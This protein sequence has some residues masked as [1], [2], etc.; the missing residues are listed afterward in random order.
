M[1]LAI[2]IIAAAVISS[3]FRALT[4]WATQYK[5]D[6][7]HHLST[8]LGEPVTISTMETGWYWFEPVIKL[9]QVEVLDGSKAVLKL[10]KLF[11]GINIFSSLWHWQIQPGVLFIDDLH[12]N[13]RQTDEGWQIDGIANRQNMAFDTETLK[14]I[15]E[16]ILDQQKI[17]LKDVSAH[18]F[19]KDGTVI[20]FDDLDLSIANHS[21]HYR[22][23][24]NAFL[25]Q[26]TATKFE[27]LADLYLDADALNKTSGHAF[28]SVHQ[29]LPAQWQKFLPQNRF[30]ILGGK[31]DVQLWA[32][33]NKGN[34]TNAQGRLNF[35]HLAWADTDTEKGQ[36][37]QSL[38]ANLAWAPQNDGS[39][40]LTGDHIGLRLSGTS[41]PE[42]SFV[43]RY[44]QTTKN[45]FIY[46]KNILLQSLCSTSIAWPESMHTI[47][48]MKPYGELHDTQ[49]Y[50]NNEKIDYV[51][52]RFV[53]LGWL[54]S[55]SR[56]GAENLSGVI[57]WQPTEGRL[58]FDSKNAVI[59]PQNQPPINF[60]LLNAAFDWK[61]LDQGLRVSM[62]RLVL[63]HS[64]LLFSAQGVADE[65]SKDSMGPVRLKAQFSA[66]NAEE[67]MPYLPSKHLK[68]K[69]DA[70]LKNDI[71]HIAKMTGELTLNG[72]MKD[73]PFDTQ[74]G[75]FSIKSYLSGV[76]LV[77]ARNWPVTREIEAYLNVTKRTL[78]ADI[79][80]AN[81]Q[82]IEVDKGNLRVND[83]GLD[84]ETLLIHTKAE[85]DAKKA[86]AYVRASP[87]NKKLSALNI[88]QMKGPVAV[89]LQLEAPL[90]PENDDILA[91]GDIVFNKNNVQVHHAIDDVELKNLSGTLQF[92]QDSVL[93]S[94][95]QAL[96]LGNPVTILIKS[97]KGPSPSTE[98]RVKGQTNISV[99]RDKFKLPVFSL[100]Q[101]SLWLESLLTITD[102]PSD[103]DHVRIQTSL[104]GLNIDLPPP[105]GKTKD[106]KV[107]LKIDID[108]NSK[109]AVRLRFNYDNRLSSD[110]LFS[111]VKGAFA[112]QKGKIILGNTDTSND[113]QL[114]GLQ[115]LGSLPEFD[116]QQW[117]AVKEKMT[118]DNQEMPN[119]LS[120]ID[121][122][123]E[124]AKVFNQSYK[125]LSFKAKKQEKGN[126]EIRLNQEKIAANLRYQP[127][128]NTVT[129]LFE[130]LHL[131]NE[132]PVDFKSASKLKPT[133]LP[134]LNLRVA[135]FQVGELNIGDV[136]LK[137]TA[138][139]DQWEL[140]TCKIKSPFYELTARGNWREN[141]KIN[142]TQLQAD[143]HITNLA[144]SLENWKVSPVVEANKGDVQFRGGWSGPIYKFSLAKLHGQLA[145]R[146]KDGR[147]TNLSP[148]TEEKLGLGK[149]LSILSL[150]TIP[151]RLKLDFSDLSEDG[152]SFDEFSGSFT[153]SKGVMATQDSYIDGPVAYA[154]MKG[155]LDI[156]KQYYDL[157]LKVNPHITASLPVVATIAGG[158]IAGIATWVAS[159]LINQGMQKI[160]GYTYKISG[161]WRQPVVQQIKI[162][163]KRN[164]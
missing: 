64:N 3:L 40:Q 18:L 116:L 7:E 155:N 140:N 143:L 157:D 75:E 80:H 29:V 4:P 11:V 84:R 68:R 156:A 81:L 82:G 73:F 133:N 96:L 117:L 15:L 154:S 152:Y 59:V 119:A 70:W 126:W 163:K 144:K 41:W 67:W 158:P 38:K 160:S 78:E 23:K 95:L 102:E 1:P 33:F 58:E 137:T 98:V 110:L 113:E 129:G 134:N 101:G 57:H 112:L 149:L 89:D 136:S 6:V 13:L 145:M 93:D 42:N 125:N 17:I 120:L 147:I 148:E 5:T 104:Q 105:L 83:L 161:P 77:F 130:K 50:V 36:L 142:T 151:R 90:Y 108:F 92:D 60:S 69:L 30:Q 100:M 66:S 20:P 14:P 115:I 16:W 27:L 87:L 124:L 85:T 22:I 79:V 21:G 71:K 106:S 76:D 114:H 47:L 91:L 55:E 2:L 146:F 31:G 10:K 19:F 123:L 43:I 49:V 121:V 127:S 37:I 94:H 46:I 164:V 97:V 63:S 138:L 34:L 139:K 74:P 54:P 99:L 8:L 132:K 65:V 45:Y 56:P 51:L 135:S 122:K 53:N 72:N 28:F 25:E 111:G 24:G 86:L 39:W 52:S 62:E 128:S 141:D 131:D 118:T 61:E 162:I 103:L 107:P 32:D 48:A 35:S 153:I 88:L 150:Q 9:N 109:K 26:T 12:L 159:K 44:Q